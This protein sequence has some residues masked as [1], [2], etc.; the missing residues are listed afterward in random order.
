MVQRLHDNALY[1]KKGFKQLGFPITL[2]PSGMVCIPQ[3]HDIS[4]QELYDFYLNH[5]IWP[6]YM[7]AGTYTSV[8][9]S[10]G[11]KFTIF[12]THTIKQLDHVL[13]DTEEFL[14]Q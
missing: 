11:I 1:L 7:K 9:P 14:T 4:L 6:N 2:N 8:P 5:Q 3:I 13:A 12:S 10:G